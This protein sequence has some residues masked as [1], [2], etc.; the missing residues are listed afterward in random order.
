[1]PDQP[2]SKTVR[3]MSLGDISNT[4]ANTGLPTISPGQLSPRGATPTSCW[5]VGMRP[6][7]QLVREVSVPLMY[8]RPHEPDVVHGPRV[9]LMYTRPHEP[10]VVH[11][12][13]V[14]LM[15][16]RPHEP[17][18]VHGPHAHSQ[19]VML[20][21]PTGPC[22]H[23]PTN[24]SSCSVPTTASKLSYTSASS[25]NTPHPHSPPMPE[26]QGGIVSAPGYDFG[27]HFN[28]FSPYT[29]NLALEYSTQQQ[30]DF[31]NEPLAPAVW[32]MDVWNNTVAIGCGCG[33][34]EVC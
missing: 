23:A 1:M 21:H 12:P 6:A 7:A 26:V 11:G 4:P 24:S 10:D 2:L 19:D 34:I 32:C 14:P 8:T 22:S 20:P 17:D 16:T 13:R 30:E 5:T 27:R 18:V 33:Q 31:S 3:S 28:L 25:D 29:S 15:Y 9:P